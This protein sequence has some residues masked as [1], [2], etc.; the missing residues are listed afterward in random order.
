MQLLQSSSKHRRLAAG[1]LRRKAQHDADSISRCRGDRGFYDMHLARAGADVTFLV[2]PGRARQLHRDGLV[3]QSRGEELRQPVRHIQAGQVDAPFDLVF[4]TCKAYDLLPAMDAIAPAAGAATVVLPVLNGLAHFDALDARFGTDRVLGGV[5]YIAA[6]LGTDGVIRHIIPR[7][8]LLFGVRGDGAPPQVP[9][10]AALF[11]TTAA[12]AR[13]TDTI[14]QDLWEKWYMLAAGAALTCL[15]RGTVGQIMATDE[16]HAIA[17][18]IMAEARAVAGAAGHAPRPA[19]A[20]EQT[21]NQLTQPSSPWAA[22]MMRD[23][24]Q[25]ASRLAAEH[26]VGDMARRGCAMGIGTPLLSAAYC[27]LQVY[28][29]RHASILPQAVPA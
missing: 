2:R 28:N 17:E 3:V 27:Q 18:A 19:A 25:G 10:L 4:L 6:M 7:D 26:I 23:I 29:A 16:G 12:S 9:A 11:S 21:R 1:T 20:A 14:L 5:C 13:A 8:L 15:M 22:S 24:E